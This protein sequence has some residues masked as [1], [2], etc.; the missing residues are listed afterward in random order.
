MHELCL[1]PWADEVRKFFL[2]MNESKKQDQADLKTACDPP[3]L[4]QYERRYDELRKM[5]KRLACYKDAYL[6][7]MRDYTAPFTNNLAERDLR[8]CKT[9]QKV[10]CCHRSWSGLRDYCKIRSFTDTV[11]KHGASVM[12]ALRSCFLCSL[13]AE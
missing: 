11:R 1:L 7:F 6:L 9:K 8:H 13:P 12:A 10:S 3:S 4:R 2:A 5:V